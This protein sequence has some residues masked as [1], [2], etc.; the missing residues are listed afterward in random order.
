MKRGG[1][2]ENGA[3][4]SNAKADWTSF[5]EALG[6][7]L[8]AVVAA[9]RPV[10]LMIQRPPGRLPLQQQGLPQW[11]YA[12]QPHIGGMHGRAQEVTL[13]FCA[14]IAVSLSS[15]VVR[16]DHCVRRRAALL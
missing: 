8:F 14:K 9:M 16:A 7:G 4:G 1:F 15:R 5:E 6:E 12:G 10:N 3:A 13:V 2:A 11:D